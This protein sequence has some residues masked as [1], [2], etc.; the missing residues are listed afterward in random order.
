MTLNKKEKKMATGA[1][2]GLVGGAMIGIPIAGA[3]AGTF[4]A[5]HHKDSKKHSRSII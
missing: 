1:V 2:I 4:V 3:L 5:A